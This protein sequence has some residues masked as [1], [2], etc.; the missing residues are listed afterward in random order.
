[1]KARKEKEKLLWILSKKQGEKINIALHLDHGKTYQQVKECIQAGFSSVMIDASDKSFSKN[2]NL[3]KKVVRYAQPRKVWVQGELGRV[4]K[5]KK[6]YQKL[7][8]SPKEFLTDPD[9]AQEFVKKTKV[10]TLAVAIGNIHGI[11]KSR[12]FHS[13]SERSEESRG[14]LY[15]AGSFAPQYCGAQDDIAFTAQYIRSYLKTYDLSI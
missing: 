1:M 10:N 7:I 13:H 4:E 3:T 11:V 9:Q 2:V 6:G 12:F 14:K 15:S 8:N 5:G